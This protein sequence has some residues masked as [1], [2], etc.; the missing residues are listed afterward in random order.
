MEKFL[1]KYTGPTAPKRT[2]T[3]AEQL[4]QQRVYDKSK[5]ERIYLPKWEQEFRWLEHS[6]I[7]MICKICK[8]YEKIRTFVNGNK[9]YKKETLVSHEKSETHVRHVLS[10]NAKNDSC[11]KDTPAAKALHNINEKTINQLAYKFRNVH[12]LSR[13][14]RPF[15]VYPLLCELDKAKGLDIGTQY[16]SK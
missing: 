12:Y 7:G 16:S 4:G 8:S 3:V 2:T 1:V 6:G 13:K 10:V 14:G 11:N 15:T 9:H 5:R